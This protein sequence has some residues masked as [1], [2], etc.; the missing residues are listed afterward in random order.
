MRNMDKLNSWS[1]NVIKH[2]WDSCRTCEGDTMKL[3]V[4]GCNLNFYHHFG[5]GEV[6][7]IDVPCPKCTHL[8]YWHL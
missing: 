7:I 4:G 8:G 5:K 1:A 6:G 3:K 2:F